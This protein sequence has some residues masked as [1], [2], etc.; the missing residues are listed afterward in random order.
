MATVAGVVLRREA[1][2]SPLLDAVPCL[3]KGKFVP[4]REQVRVSARG[5]GPVGPTWLA[6]W[7]GTR[8]GMGVMDGGL[9][10]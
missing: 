3:A 2:I 7:S 1:V 8:R 4:S 10:R 9:P 6:P 5:L